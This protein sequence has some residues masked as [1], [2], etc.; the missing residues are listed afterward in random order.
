[1]P[2]ALSGGGKDAECIP[3]S[4]DGAL[5]ASLDVIS[6]AHTC[7]G[8]VC[9]APKLGL[10]GWETVKSR[11]GPE[12]ESMPRGLR[13]SRAADPCAWDRVQS[14]APKGSES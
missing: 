12:R 11:E 2:R 14:G 3:F 1:M 13:L 10:Q 8:V 4:N 5:L 6:L 9:P 7:E